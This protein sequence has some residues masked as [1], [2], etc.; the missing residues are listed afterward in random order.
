MQFI[1]PWK[2]LHSD[3]LCVAEI[4]SQAPPLRCEPC[5]ALGFDLETVVSSLACLKYISISARAC[6]SQV[7]V[8]FQDGDRRGN[9]KCPVTEVRAL[10]SL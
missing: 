9:A 1:D 2:G 5:L 7:Q 3:L 4:V 8:E 10:R 6:V